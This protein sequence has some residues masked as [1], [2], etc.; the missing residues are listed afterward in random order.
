MNKIDI[1]S[2]DLTSIL[3]FIIVQANIS[4]FYAHLQIAIMFSP[5]TSRSASIV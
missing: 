2:Q 4:V 3:L 5:P 1:S